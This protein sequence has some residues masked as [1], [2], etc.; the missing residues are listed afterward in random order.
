MSLPE[1]PESEAAGRIAE[2]YRA[3]LA[4]TGLPSTNLVWRHMAS[5]PGVLEWAY[6]ALE[7]GVFGRRL[8]HP[9]RRDRRRDC[10][11][12]PMPRWPKT[13][14]STARPWNGPLP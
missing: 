14:A 12:P 7:S 4:A 10:R 2:I 8:P 13:R 9:R 1:I 6:D 3:I 11:P 5:R